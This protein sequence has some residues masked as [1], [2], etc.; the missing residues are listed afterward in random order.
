MPL[1][2]EL[3]AELTAAIERRS[4][5]A[6]PSR[7]W[8]RLRRLTPLSAVLVIST[9]AALAATGVIPI[10]SPVPGSG[11]RPDPN[12][13]AGAMVPGATMTLPIRVADPDGG[14]EWGMRLQA[15]T[16]R[17]VCIQI[18]RVLNGKLGVLGQNGAF[19]NDGRFHPLP[20][21]VESSGCG[22]LDTRGNASFGITLNSV[23]VNGATTGLLGVNVARCKPAACPRRDRRDIYA[24]LLGRDAQS[25]TYVGDDGALQT[26]PTVGPY[27]AY[28]LVRRTEAT[29]GG[30]SI[31]VGADPGKIVR[32][33]T[34][35]DGRACTFPARTHGARPKPC[36]QLTLRPAHD[37]A[38]IATPI[39]VRAERHQGRQ[40]WRITVS[41][42]S[43]VAITTADQAY[44]VL[45]RPPRRAN[46]GYAYSVKEIHQDVAAGELITNR[47]YQSAPGTY[48][49]E[50]RL[51]TS[52]ATGFVT[53]AKDGPLVGRFRVRVP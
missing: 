52:G 36:G 32:K 41:F 34:F 17:A 16:R 47:Y 12:R 37:R 48:R 23:P 39:H 25:V 6:K 28:L 51:A 29:R 43:R 10:G 49:G 13:G 27:G 1:I 15:T 11:D 45:L 38:Q 42:R 33:V 44:T 40:K 2:P 19:S 22:A 50:V 31:G 8:R 9:A 24:G 53:D 3:D 4:A 26:I 30:T 20:A 7:T 35:R 21:S 14:P 46:L 5:D 18:A